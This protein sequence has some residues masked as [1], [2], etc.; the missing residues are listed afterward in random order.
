MGLIRTVLKYPSI[1]LNLINSLNATTFINI[2]LSQHN[3]QGFNLN[4][5]L[6]ILSNKKPIDFMIQ[7][8]VNS[9]I[10]F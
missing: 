6:R 5:A 1:C 2:E 3:F 4:I 8:N 10:V 9:R 7:I